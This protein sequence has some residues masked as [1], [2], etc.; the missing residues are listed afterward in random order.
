MGSVIVRGGGA[1]FAQEVSVGRHRLV[2]DEPGDAGGG[3]AGPG[4]YDY[5]LVALGSCTSMTIALYA[6]RK[7]WPLEGVTV[8]LRH[9]RVHA[10]D[11]AGCETQEARL[12]RIDR[13]IALQGA[14]DE[15]QRARLLAIA[16]RCP[17]H[18][19]LVAG[20]DIRTR[21]A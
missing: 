1:G 2:A 15:A 14:L 11:C 17:V 18:R 8:E 5:L 6:R 16:E 7:G 4:P 13:E 12:D 20:V 3:D 10:S 9:S 19:T 21:L